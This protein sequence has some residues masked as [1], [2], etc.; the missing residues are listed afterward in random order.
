MSWIRAVLN[1]KCGRCGLVIEKGAPMQIVELHRVARTLIRC[2]ACANEPVPALPALP[3]RVIGA[4][5]MKPLTMHRF[6]VDR[7]PVDFKMAQAGREPG[8]DG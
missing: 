2:A 6:D 3:E 8:E 1:R 7:L 5:P 4:V